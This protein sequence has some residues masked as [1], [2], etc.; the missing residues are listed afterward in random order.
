MLEHLY[1]NGDRLAV[2]DDPFIDMDAKRVKQSCEL[3][4]RFAKNNQVI[5]V[6]CDPQYQS[7]LSGNIVSV[8]R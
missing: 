3:I 8:S 6:T 4:Q 5:F 1:P 2:F 7:Y